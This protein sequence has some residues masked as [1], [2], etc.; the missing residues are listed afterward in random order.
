MCAKEGQKPVCIY[1]AGEVID[2]NAPV[3]DKL[4]VVQQEAVARKRRNANRFTNFY[5]DYKHK[6]GYA[7]TTRPSSE[8]SLLRLLCE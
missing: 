8:F 4:V 2:D 5:N 7:S 3:H 1:L 6:Q